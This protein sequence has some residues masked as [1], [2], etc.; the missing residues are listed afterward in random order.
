MAKKTQIE[1]LVEIT[2]DLGEMVVDQNGT[3]FMKTQEGEQH[4][5]ISIQSLSF[6]DLL[7]HQ[8]FELNGMLAFSPNLKEVIDH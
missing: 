5:V 4:K 1:E 2:E 7:R 8:Y 6:L 3:P